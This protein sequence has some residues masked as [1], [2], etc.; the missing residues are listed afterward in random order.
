LLG[1]YDGAKTLLQKAMRSDQKNF[2]PDHPRTATRYS[3]LALMLKAVGDYEEALKLS[4]K[5]V[6]IFTKV[7]PA[8]HP[9]IKTVTENYNA[10]KNDIAHQQSFAE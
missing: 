4:E 10:I 2:G 1:N 9:T 5:A 3:N 7:L 6:Q 8:G